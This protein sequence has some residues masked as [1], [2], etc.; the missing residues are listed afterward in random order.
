M[1][2]YPLFHGDKYVY[3]SFNRFL[4]KPFSSLHTGLFIHALYAV[5]WSLTSNNSPCRS[6]YL[7]VAPSVSLSLCLCF[8]LSVCLC[9][10]LSIFLLFCLCL[11]RC[12][13]VSVSVAV[14]LSL[15]VCQSVCL[16]SVCLSACL[17]FYSKCRFFGLCC[18]SFTSL[19]V[20]MYVKIVHLR[21]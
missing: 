15:S 7:C 6:V 1:R 11:C 3:K 18:Y 2:I 4:S 16:L 14:S 21:R 8:C 5:D 10:P 19:N 20:A 13:T 12:L 9:L 17:S